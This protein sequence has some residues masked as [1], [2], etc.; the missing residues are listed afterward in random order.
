MK[1]NELNYRKV[2]NR[3]NPD[4]IYYTYPHWDIREIDGITF[5]PV[6]KFN[7]SERKS[8]NTFYMRKDTLEYIK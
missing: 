3:L 7:P 2:R 6:V 8:Q 1:K 4:E 5:L